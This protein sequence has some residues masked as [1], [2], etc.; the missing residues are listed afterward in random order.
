MPLLRLALALALALL[1]S[2]ALPARAAPFATCDAYPAAATPKPTVATFFVDALPGVDAP[3]TDLAKPCH[4][5][6]AAFATGTHT[7]SAT[8]GIVDPVKGRLNSV[9]SNT[10][11]FTFGVAPAAPTGLGITNN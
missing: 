1:A 9:K 3:V 10:V 2:L 4:Y 6:L 11:N 8:F 7:V 5:D